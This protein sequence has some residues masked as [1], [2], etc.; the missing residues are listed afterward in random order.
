VTGASSYSLSR[1]G[2]EI[3]NGSDLSYDDNALA[4]G[5]TYN[6]TILTINSSGE[7]GPVS[8]PIELTTH[9]EVTAPELSLSVSESTATLNWTS[10]SSADNY[11]IYQDSS[12][13]QEVDGTTLEIDIGTGSETCF[14]VTAVDQ[15][16]TESDHSNEECGTGS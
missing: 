11:R 4:Y 16:D 1:D 8:S 3:Y 5:T 15:Y 9:D 13:V 12:F 7:N 14:T 6:Y 2:S 10:I